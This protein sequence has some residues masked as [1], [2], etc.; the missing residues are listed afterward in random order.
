MRR[1]T[2][3]PTPGGGVGGGRAVR[4]REG[5]PPHLWGRRSRRGSS[6]PPR[7][8]PALGTPPRRGGDARA[9]ALR[10]DAVGQFSQVGGIPQTRS[11]LFVKVD[12]GDPGVTPGLM[13]CPFLAP[14]PVPHQALALMWCCSSFG[15]EWAG[16]RGPGR[17]EPNRTIRAPEARACGGS[18]RGAKAR[19]R[20]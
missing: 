18:D 1:N 12:K 10:A 14:V 16:V 4:N 3:N 8:P 20:G 19:D 9:G 15:V 17:W 5:S 7:P 6:P 13:D 2:C 11:N